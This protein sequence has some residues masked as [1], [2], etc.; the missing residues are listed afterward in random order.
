MDV[1]FLQQ[2]AKLPHSVRSAVSSTLTPSAL[3]ETQISVFCTFLERKRPLKDY[4]FD[5]NLIRLKVTK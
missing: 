3:D 4:W 1:G 5:S 2:F